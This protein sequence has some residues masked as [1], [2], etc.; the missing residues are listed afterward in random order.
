MRTAAAAVAL[1]APH[2]AGAQTWT[3]PTSAF[4]WLSDGKQFNVYQDCIFKMQAPA[5]EDLKTAKAFYAEASAS[6]HTG[7]EHKDRS[8]MYLYRNLNT[9][10]QL[11]F[12]WIHGIDDHK[13]RP[14]GTGIRDYGPVADFQ[15]EACVWSQISDFPPGTRIAEADDSSNEFDWHDELGW[16]KTTPSHD[17]ARQ[18]MAGRWHFKD[19]TDGM[20]LDRI[21]LDKDWCMRIEVNFDDPKMDPD[22]RNKMNDWRFF[23]ADGS[24][25]QLSLDRPVYICSEAQVGGCSGCPTVGTTATYCGMADD[26]ANP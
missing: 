10:D 21:P 20:T 25:Q 1:C 6:A 14:G 17:P 24:D 16:G 26:A 12:F 8:L 9:P 19:N 13:D 11:S 7:F 15:Q 22:C 23:F 3:C 18:Y 5:V 4:K 2:H